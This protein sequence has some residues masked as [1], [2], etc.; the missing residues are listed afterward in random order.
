MLNGGNLLV[1]QKILGHQSIQ[2]TMRYAHL[3][4]DHLS[5]AVKF[6]PKAPVDTLLT[7]GEKAEEKGGRNNR[8]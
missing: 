1:L 8:K 5:E 3:S 7:Q 6:G 2:M 4:P